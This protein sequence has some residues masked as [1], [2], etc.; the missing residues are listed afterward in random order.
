MR[1]AR[2]ELGVLLLTT[3]GRI[4]G[5]GAVECIEREPLT[6]WA[7]AG[8][9]TFQVECDGTL[10]RVVIYH[11]TFG[12]IEMRQSSHPRLFRGKT[13]TIGWDETPMLWPLGGKLRA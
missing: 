3:D 8:R 5:G 1:Q 7:S 2:T 12:E 13:V 11:H 4:A 9:V 10:G 6:Y